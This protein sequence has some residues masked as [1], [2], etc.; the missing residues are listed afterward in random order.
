MKKYFFILF[1][2]FCSSCIAQNPL[3]TQANKK[4]NLA[5]TV[6]YDARQLPIPTQSYFDL[7]FSHVSAFSVSNPIAIPNNKKYM[8]WGFINVDMESNWRREL[9]PFNND[10]NRLR[11]EW[12]TSLDRIDRHYRSPRD[13]SKFEFMVLDVE[14]KLHEEQLKAKPPFQ[15]GRTK[16]ATRAIDEY[17]E[18]MRKL[19]NTSLQYAK[20]N[21]PYYNQ[22]SSYSDVPIENTWWTIP[23]YSWQEW[24]SNPKYL[25]YI[26]HNIANGKPV[27]TDFAK[28]LDFFTPSTYYF[29][30]PEV[31]G[32]Q[33][34]SQYLAYMLFQ[35]EANKAWT[36][37]PIILYHWF[38][39]QG[40][41]E[42][43]AFI[44]ETMVR[45]SVLFAFVSGADGMVLYDD[46]RDLTNNREYI[47]RVAVF[48]DA[49]YE[50]SKYNNYFKDKNTTFFKP[51]NPRDLFVSLKPIVRGIV[52]DNKMLIV[53]ANPFAKDSQT[54]DISVVYNNKRINLKLKGKKALLTEIDLIN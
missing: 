54:S 44:D 2:L 30:S 31:S 1:I 53:A 50:L 40:S 9:S 47:K 33:V 28:G 22:W 11:R 51:E 19:Y 23:Y 52:K 29:Y 13:R 42:N 5:K 18:E 26:T 48:S 39:Y 49:L 20:Q 32:E 12:R 27:E 4:I 10:M 21:Y 15:K 25:N 37:K 35:L 45:N 17:K 3:Q 41:R 14:A 6:I 8:L 16:V 7:G 46:D 43:R 24:T 36:N 34:S 38:A